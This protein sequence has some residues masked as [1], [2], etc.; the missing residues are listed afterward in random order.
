MNDDWLWGWD[1][2]PAI[3]SV[4]AEADG[5]AQVWR[6]LAPEAALVRE[7]M[8]FR[9]WL[10]L[11]SLDDLGHLGSRLRPE[12]A[13]PPPTAWS[14]VTYRELEG[15]GALRYL[16]RAH[17]GRLLVRWLLAGVGRRTGR[18]PGH[19]RELDPARVLMLAPEEQYLVASGRTYFRG[20]LFDDLR[21]AQFDLETTGLDPRSDRIFLC[22]LGA[23]DG[24]CE[25]LEAAGE[26]DR[27]EAELIA[28]LMAR[29]QAL[30]PDVIEN[31]NL[32]GF[33]LP[34]LAERA[35][36]LGVPLRLGRAGPAGLRQ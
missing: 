20:M 12:A 8:R 28:R 4:W 15:D 1:H 18:T 32:H 6:R 2:T 35:R 29:L 10:L 9:P 34:F 33:D 5:R 7:E 22:A 30:D 36:R 19:I 23:P 16:V 24:G 31:H 11:A 13:E 21:R 25:V 26:G 14:G 27:A 3:V 17:D